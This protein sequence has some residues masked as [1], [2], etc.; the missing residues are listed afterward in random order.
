IPNVPFGKFILKS[1]QTY[2]DNL[3]WIDIGNGSEEY[4]FSRIYNETCKCANSLIKEGIKRGDIVGIL[5]P[6]SCQQK[7]LVLALALCGATIVPIN[8]FYT[9]DEV[10]RQMQIVQPTVVFTTSDQITKLQTYSENI[11]IYKFG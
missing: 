6:N 1:I 5:C 3:A 8:N 9:E 7:I 10:K 11:K 2:G 4:S